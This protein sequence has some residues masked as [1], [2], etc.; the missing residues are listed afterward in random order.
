[1]KRS[2]KAKSLWPY[3]KKSRMKKTVYKEERK[4]KITMV[5]KGTL[6]TIKCNGVVSDKR[7][8]KK[9]ELDGIQVGLIARNIRMAITDWKIRGGIDTEKLLKKKSKKKT[10]TTRKKKKS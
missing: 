2:L 10:S 9:G 6:L 5:R 3:N 8:F 1:M 4:V 7:N